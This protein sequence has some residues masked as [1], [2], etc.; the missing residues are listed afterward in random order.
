MIVGVSKPDSKK[1]EMKRKKKAQIFEE[2]Q[3][4]MRVLAIKAQ[5]ESEREADYERER[6]AQYE[7][8]REKCALP[9]EA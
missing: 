7:S 6:A 4:E 8:R 5:Y 1:A 2:R 9:M 3:C